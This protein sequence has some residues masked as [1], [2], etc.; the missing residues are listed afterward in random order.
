MRRFVG[1]NV[2]FTLFTAPI[3]APVPLRFPPGPSG[4]FA[5]AGVLAH[6]LTAPASVLVTLTITPALG[7][8]LRCHATPE[9]RE[10]PIP[11]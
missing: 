6:L 8:S 4:S 9:H 5:G 10:P 7:L 1:V 2:R 11:P 3:A